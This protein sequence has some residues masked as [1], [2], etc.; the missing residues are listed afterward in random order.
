MPANK[1]NSITMGTD[2]SLD[3]E[4]ICWDSAP[5]NSDGSGGNGTEVCEPSECS[6]DPNSVSYNL[7]RQNAIGNY[8]L[9]ASDLINNEYT[10]ANLGYYEPYCY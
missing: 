5:P 8:T 10:D 9:L 7:Y 6:Q 4:Y 1:Y 2:P 3:G